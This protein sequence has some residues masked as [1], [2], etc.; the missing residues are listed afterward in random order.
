MFELR[1]Q[2]R[3]LVKDKNYYDAIIEFCEHYDFLE[4]EEELT[5]FLKSNDEMVYYIYLFNRYD[6]AIKKSGHL[7]YLGVYNESEDCDLFD[8]LEKITIDETIKS[9]IKNLKTIVLDKKELCPECCGIGVWDDGVVC[10]NC[11]G[12]G[13]IQ[14]ANQKENDLEFKKIRERIITNL[15]YACKYYFESDSKDVLEIFAVM[16]FVKTN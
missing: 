1:E 11:N 10:L 13:L 16:K 3:E 7:G 2:I 14:S 12:S 15:K 9:R 6:N 8:F 5:D 4:S